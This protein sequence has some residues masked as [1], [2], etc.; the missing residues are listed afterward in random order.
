MGKAFNKAFSRLYWFA[1]YKV[2]VTA[3]Y[4]YYAGIC[5]IKLM[6]K[7]IDADNRDT[8]FASNIVD[9]YVVSVFTIGIL[10]AK[11]TTKTRFPLQDRLTTTIC[12]T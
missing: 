1:C 4:A 10:F 12:I 8:A 9:G 5:V 7:K 2:R 6:T 11:I 3:L